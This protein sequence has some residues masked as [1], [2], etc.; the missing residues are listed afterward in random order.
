M[1]L[2]CFFFKSYTVY[3]HISIFLCWWRV[4]A[5]VKYEA[6]A[7]NVLALLSDTDGEIV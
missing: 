7:D 5:N 1:T 6:V 4:D 3:Q 2:F